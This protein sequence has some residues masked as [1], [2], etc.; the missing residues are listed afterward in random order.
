MTALESAI[1]TRLQ[2]LQPQQ[3]EI[4][5][6]SALHAGHAGAQGG[7]KHY[8]LSI[9]S[10]Q[11]AGRNTL[12]RHRLVYEALGSLMHRDIHALAIQARAPGES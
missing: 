5:D 3:L 8:R 1:R 6:E 12:A 11:F 7:G 9:V 2:A 10:A 4:A